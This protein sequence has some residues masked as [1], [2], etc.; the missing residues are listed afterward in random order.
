MG[1]LLALGAALGFGVSDYTG[2]LAA[3]RGS[4]LTV[5]LLGQVAGLLA[6]V[7]ALVLVA[8]R[9]S[10]AAL[11]YGA[12]A[13]LFGSLGLVLYLRCMALGPMG[14]I[15]PV[16]ALVGAAVPVLWAVGLA[17]ERL[18]PRDVAGVVAGLAAVVLVAYR[19]GA[20]RAAAGSRGPLVA[21]GAGA[22]FGLFLVLL[23]ATPGDSGLWP[24]V[25]SR[26]AGIG[27]LAALV[28]ARPRPWPST[29]G[30]R[31]AVVSGVT[32]QLANVSFLLATR[33]GLLSLAS[34]LT[35]LYPVVVL[36]LARQL[37]HERLTRP[38]AGGVALALLTSVLIAA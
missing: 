35:S 7:P 38:Q 31:L 10:F 16:A 37:L 15:S 30:R 24:L 13:G 36:V 8:G 12:A 2:G 28:R 4:A 21:A 18:D 27:L 6:L 34:L 9:P 14:V 20:G 5:T 19:R 1:S 25:G 33:T 17:G 26:L 3:R 22:A 29:D 32:D 11:G 23:D